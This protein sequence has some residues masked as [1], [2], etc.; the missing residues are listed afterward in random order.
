MK[1]LVQIATGPEH[2][3]RAILGLLYARTALDEG[4]EVS[5]FFAG[6]GAGIVRVETLPLLHGV[7]PGSATEHL[8]RLITGGA[9]IYVS[10]PAAEARGIDLAHVGARG[11]ELA[12]P[13]RFVELVAEAE[14]TLVY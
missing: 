6:D 4:H 7:G 9:H 11:A 14:R 3:T 5:V 1:L 8:E 13:A 2:P 10:A 12:S